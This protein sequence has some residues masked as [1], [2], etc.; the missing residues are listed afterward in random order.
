MF[1]CVEI[2]PNKYNIFEIYKVMIK[3]NNP[4]SNLN[5]TCYKKNVLKLF[6]LS[7]TEN[8]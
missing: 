1:L 7:I 4:K 6:V 2:M 8:L 5:I 3:V